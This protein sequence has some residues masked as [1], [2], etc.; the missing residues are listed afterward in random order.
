MVVVCSNK[1]REL[2]R[3][4]IQFRLSRSIDKY[5]LADMLDLMLDI[6]IE[7][8]KELGGYDP[9]TQKYKSSL[10]AHTRT[11]LKQVSDLLIRMVLKR[12]FCK[13]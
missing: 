6:V 2:S 9:D 10:S 5:A 8:A 7:C 3:H 12:L 1:M 11:S 13:M 4:L